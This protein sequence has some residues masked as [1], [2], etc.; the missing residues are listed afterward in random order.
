VFAF[1]A[2]QLWGTGLVTAREQS[3]GEDRIMEYFE[4]A[5]TE[6]R[7]GSGQEI[8]AGSNYGTFEIPVDDEGRVA[9]EDLPDLNFGKG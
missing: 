5:R 6:A 1:V 7:S 2:Y 3:L 8:P 9:E 4:E